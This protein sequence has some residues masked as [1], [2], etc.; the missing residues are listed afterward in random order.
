[1]ERKPQVQKSFDNES[2]L[3]GGRLGVLLLLGLSFHLTCR[4]WGAAADS[5][6]TFLASLGP[7]FPA[8][9]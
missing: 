7:S 5:Q 2:G 6:V 4:A 3:R 1:M 8:C 9:M